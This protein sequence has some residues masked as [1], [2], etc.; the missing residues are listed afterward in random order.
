MQFP[1]M[2]GP[3]ERLSWGGEKSFLFENCALCKNQWKLV[4]W[5]PGHV[6]YCRQME[7]WKHFDRDSMWC[8]EGKEWVMTG[9][10]DNCSCMLSFSFECV[11]CV[12]VCASLCV[13]CVSVSCVCVCVCVCIWMCV[14][15]R[16]C[17]VCVCVC[18]CVH[19]V[20]V[21]LSTSNIDTDGLSDTHVL[22]FLFCF[23]DGA[24]H[25]CCLCIYIL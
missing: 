8:T 15:V 13:S 20:C 21:C 14:C 16:T 3:Q 2:D 17:S 19:V 22:P 25:Q 5:A 10:F 9:T 12:C 4:I 24:L 11:S 1:L 18:V 7:N 23:L 6:L